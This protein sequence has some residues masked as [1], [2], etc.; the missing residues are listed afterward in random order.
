[1][2]NT[3]VEKG[4]DRSRSATNRDTDVLAAAALRQHDLGPLGVGS[5]GGPKRRGATGCYHLAW[6][7]TS[8]TRPRELASCYS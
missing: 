6:K 1:M 3:S 4:T 5:T 7:S 8:W 2:S